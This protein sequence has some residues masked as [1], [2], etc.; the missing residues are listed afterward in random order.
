MKVNDVT[1]DESRISVIVTNL[2][3]NGNLVS[4]PL[5]LTV[6]DYLYAEIIV[7]DNL[8]RTDTS[9]VLTSN[10]STSSL[11]GLIYFKDSHAINSGASADGSHH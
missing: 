3:A 7:E 5:I 6:E 8:D 10:Q 11:A 1:S 9:T 2:K 4:D